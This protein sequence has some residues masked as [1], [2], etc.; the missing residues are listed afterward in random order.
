M[1]ATILF[2][3]YISQYTLPITLD[4]KPDSQQE[5]KMITL[6]LIQKVQRAIVAVIILIIEV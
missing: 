2:D 3:V 5:K 6:A 1:L 4:L